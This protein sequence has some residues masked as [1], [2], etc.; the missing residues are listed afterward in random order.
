MSEGPP[1]PLVLHSTISP[2]TPSSPLYPDGVITPVWITKHQA[3]LPAIFMTFL[4]LAA[5]PNQ[6]SLQD[7]LLKS[8]I[9]N[10]RN[11]IS[12]TNYKTK[13]VVVFLSDGTITS[14]IWDE[15]I[16]NIRKS[17]TM[18]SK[19]LFH[20]PAE[21]SEAEIADFV[22]NLLST[23][24]PIC[25]EYYRD[26]S[27]H[28]RRKRN[29][30][31]TPPP[32]IAP[33]VGTS[34]VLPMQGWNSRYEFKLGVFAEFRQEMDAACRNYESAYESLFSPELFES[35]ASW[36]PRF[37]ETRMLADVIA[38]RIIRC[39]LWTEQPTGAVRS[40]RNHRDR[41]RDI[42][43][44][45]GKGTENC[46][47]EAWESIW[48]KTMAHMI[49]RAD[50]SSFAVSESHTQYTS[51]IF[52]YPEKSLPIGERVAPWELL[53]HAGYWLANA[54]KHT[55]KRRVLASRSFEQ[56]RQNSSESST[57]TTANRIRHSDSY[58]VAELSEGNALTG[59]S[60][61]DYQDDL[62]GTL[63]SA[64]D[65]F[66]ARGQL[67]TN[68]RLQLE[69]AIDLL[70]EKNWSD[71]AKILVS[72]WKNTDWRSSGWWNFLERIGWALYQCALHLEDQELVIRLMWELSSCVFSARP[73]FEYDLRAALAEFK[74]AD[75]RPE[76]V[77][78]SDEIV[79]CVV[80]TFAFAKAEGNVGQSLGAQLCISC[81]TQPRASTIHFSE[82]K[83]VF[84]GGLRPIYLLHD[85]SLIT[86]NGTDQILPV[87]LQDTSTF[88]ASSKK[89][90]SSGAI[91]SLA[92][93]ANLTFVAGQSK[94]YS[95]DITPREAGDVKIASISMIIEDTR[96]SLTLVSSGLHDEA[97][98]WW[99]SKQKKAM[100]RAFAMQ[101]DATE[102]KILPK[103]PMVHV[104]AIEL[105]EAYYTN[106]SVH[107][108]FNV[109][110]SEE[111]AVSLSLR[112][113]LISPRAHAAALRWEDQDG[114]AR[115]ESESEVGV[116][117]LPNRDLVTLE[118]GESASMTL[119]MNNTLDALDHEFE[120][121]ARY[122][123]ASD[124][125][126]PL[127]KVSTFDLPFMRPFEANYNFS[128]RYDD[129]VWPNFFKAPGPDDVPGTGLRQKYHVNANICSFASRELQLD[130]ASLV[131]H[132]TV[133][134][135]VCI[136][137]P[138]YRKPPQLHDGINQP[139][140]YSNMIAPE[141]AQDF[142]FDLEAQKLKLGDRHA[143]GV[144]LTLEIAWRRPGSLTSAVSTLEIPRFIPPMAEPRVLLCDPTKLGL[145]SSGADLAVYQVK[146]ILENPSMHF[147]TF[148]I[149]MDS[150]EDFA[151]SGPKAT[152]VSLV[153]VSRHAVEYRL[154]LSKTGVWIGVN[155][156]VVDAYFGKQLRVLPAGSGVRSDKKGTVSVWIP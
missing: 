114:V 139:V 54:L 150:S 98:Y 90:F 7:N 129:E 30:G 57:P 95:F 53:H 5:D 87:D 35:I 151:F 127:T 97:G 86:N 55:R 133:G 18:D 64:M 25:V 2:L 39:Q 12:S 15:R 16:S 103:P 156:G 102:T 154:L 138:G 66:M 51:P 13:L 68:Q 79:S 67:R 105:K 62:S 130:S 6:S 144:D 77:L 137:S 45:K 78:S 152:S 43:N 38:I 93:G 4:P 60:A 92:G 118:P 76:I 88:V 94:V 8:E 153:P 17:C 124:P 131:V 89:R 142:G 58:L 34:Q 28:A 14:S 40:W 44:R 26:L 48:S 81:H 42:I 109:I 147:L 10:I 3:R 46:D 65:S 99:D 9:H 126:T 41:I 106:E 70:D 63:K 71:A 143:V 111:E 24:H 56:A 59:Q 149:T 125:E 52:A 37:N 134:G 1:A 122:H 110:N 104:E 75:S 82:I 113:R 69:E 107:L 155:L 128:A 140:T 101:R 117:A 91:A 20:L 32:T 36:S 50:L 31:H 21:S 141:E 74:S 115:P 112:A 73:G 33:T 84:E 136:T 116:L 27:K 11:V 123:I 108:Q 119:L 146:F 85:D 72:L 145:N 121:I 49:A 23:L 100:P 61:Y 29:R 96:F 22:Q 47:W 19:S 80:P 120:I 148:N 135:A 132:R 83:V